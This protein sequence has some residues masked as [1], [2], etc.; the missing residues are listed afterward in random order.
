M[1]VNSS[2]DA[3]HSDRIT[4]LL[5]PYHVHNVFKHILVGFQIHFGDVLNSAD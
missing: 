3:D 2:Q 4:G 1:E 5:T